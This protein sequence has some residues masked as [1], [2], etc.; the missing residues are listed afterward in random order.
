MGWST[1]LYTNISFN[2]KTYNNKFEVEDN[3]EEIN[4]CIKTCQNTIRDLVLMTEPNKYFPEGLEQTTYNQLVQEYESQ[5]ELLEEYLVEQWKLTI[6]LDR[7]DECHNDDG[8]AINPPT[9][10]NLY[11]DS[12][13][14]GDFVKT[15]EKKDT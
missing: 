13:L 12:F 8:F 1:E 15:S 2:R 3:L 6:L 5:M 7:W 11:R 4:R 14:W 10:I 9:D